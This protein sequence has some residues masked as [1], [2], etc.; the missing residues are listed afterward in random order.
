VRSPS[1]R[2][3]LAHS[4]K[5]RK[6]VMIASDSKRS[7]TTP[8]QGGQPCT[9][10]TLSSSPRAPTA[11]CA[12]ATS[13]TATPARTVLDTGISCFS[14]HH[15]VEVCPGARHDRFAAGWA[16]GRQHQVQG[17]AAGSGA[18]A[19][20]AARAGATAGC[21]GTG[22]PA[23]VAGTADGDS[24]A[25]IAIAWRRRTCSAC[26]GGIAGAPARAVTGA[27]SHPSSRAWTRVMPR[28]GPADDDDVFY[29][30]LQKQKSA[31]SY[32]PQGY[33]PPYEAV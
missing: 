6:N 24:T 33:F 20:A 8:C 22:S 19:R 16:Q 18:F 28:H 4:R 26:G 10:P 13:A 31:L 11:A 27:S 32:I 5:H 14:V 9:K 1:S 12:S 21:D 23:G 30:F 29:L 25:H 15:R 2:A 7:R 3:T 17:Q